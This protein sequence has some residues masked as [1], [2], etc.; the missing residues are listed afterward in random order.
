MLGLAVACYGLLFGPIRHRLSQHLPEGDGVICRQCLAAAEC[1]GLSGTLSSRTSRLELARWVWSWPDTACYGLVCGPIRHC[2]PQHLPEGD[3][4][5]CRQWL[6]TAACAVLSGTLSSRTSRLELARWVWSWPDTACYGLVCGPIRHCL[7]QQPPEGD[8]VICRQW[9]ATA[10]CAVLSGTLSSRTSRLELARWVWSWPDTA[11]YGL[12]CGPIRHCLP[13]HLPEG[14]R[15][16]CRQ[17]LATAACAVLSGTLSSRTSRL[18]LARWVWSWPD[19]A[20]YGLVCGPIRHCL[21]QQ[22]PEGDGVICR[23]WL[24]TAACAVLSGTLSSRTSRL[25]LARWVWSWPDTACYGLVCGPIRHCLPQ[26]LPEGDRVVCRQW[27]ATAACAVLSGTLSSRTSRLELARWVWSWPDTACYGLVCGPIR[28]CL[29]QHL[30]E[31]DRVVC[32]QWLATAACAVLSGTLSSR[33]S[34]LELARW[35]WSWPDTAC[36]GLVCGPIRHCL[37]QHLPEGDRVVCRPWL[38]TAACAVLSGTLSSRASRLELVCGVGSWPDTACYGLVC[39]PIRH[40][41]PQ[42]LPEGDRVVCRQWLATAACAVLS[43]TLS[44]RTSRLELARWVW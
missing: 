6:A 16:V 30:P 15:V 25:E 26:H 38:A 1:A 20:C 2:L 24:A 11:C 4:V 39:G 37:P 23:Q 3:R 41:L 27:L 12:V 31:G 22:P 18:E 34:R 28:H 40:C 13:Q 36:Y 33:T 35:V 14:D 19:T 8:G 43:G 9:L 5:V 44:S 10:A 32:R 42:H 17:W 7:S 21:S 29:P